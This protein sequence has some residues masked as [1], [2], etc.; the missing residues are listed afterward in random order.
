MKTLL[1]TI[2]IW[3]AIACNVP[4]Q[5]ESIS[6]PEN[7]EVVLPADWKLISE[8]EIQFYIPPDLKEEKIQ[9]YDSCVIQLRSKNISLGI[10]VLEG[11]PD[12][13]F[14]RSNEYSRRN[15]FRLEKTVIDKQH[16]EI[17]TFS[18]A[19]K[20][21]NAKD[22]DFGA[23]LDVPQMNLTMWAY[24]KSPEERENVIKI[25][26]SVRSHKEQSSRSINN[27]KNAL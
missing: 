2:L 11:Q 27:L 6:I 15:N 10:D 14:S 22:L 24:S 7:K 16:A 17:T 3:T 8:C 18:G 13:D 5:K 20:D 12:S 23:V 25:F 4:E 21:L 1:I 26:K 9:P 19:G